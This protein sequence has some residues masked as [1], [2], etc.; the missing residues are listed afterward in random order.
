MGFTV[1]TNVQ[2]LNAWLKIIKSY[3]PYLIIAYGV[4][5]LMEYT[6]ILA[7]TWK[8]PTTKILALSGRLKN[9]LNYLL[10][11]LISGV[12]SR[13]M[14]NWASSLLKAEPKRPFPIFKS[15]KKAKSCKWKKGSIKHLLL[16]CRQRPELLK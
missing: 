1:H 11:S 8:L 14:T 10:R 16:E 15:W 3:I 7:L 12:Y 13:N 2:K 6:K 5:G 9:L 4:Y